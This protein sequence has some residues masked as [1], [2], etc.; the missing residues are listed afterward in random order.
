MAESLT[1]WTVLWKVFSKFIFSFQNLFS[2][3][4][5]IFFY[6]SFFFL[7]FSSIEFHFNLFNIDFIVWTFYSLLNL[8]NLLFSKCLDLVCFFHFKCKVIKIGSS[9]LNCLSFFQHY[10]SKLFN[11]LFRKVNNILSFY[12][13]FFE[14]SF[15]SGS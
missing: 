7:N 10:L 6:Q 8:K 9:R 12:Q 3:L 5:I 13:L 2:Q 15:F 1:G 4:C 14:I 11:F